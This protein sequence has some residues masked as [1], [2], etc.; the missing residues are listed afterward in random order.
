VNLFEV[1]YVIGQWSWY[2]LGVGV[3]LVGIALARMFWPVKRTGEQ[4]VVE[5]APVTFEQGVVKV[6]D[7]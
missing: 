5:P 3:V 7:R 4:A 1:L 6:G 2:L